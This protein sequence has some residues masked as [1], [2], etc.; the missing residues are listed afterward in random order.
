MYKVLDNL[1]INDT[2][3]FTLNGNRMQTVL[4]ISLKQTRIRN[5][6]LVQYR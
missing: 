3:L 6:Y 5:T 1:S 2:I 4:K